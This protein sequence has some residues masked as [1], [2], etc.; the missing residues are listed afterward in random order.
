MIIACII[1]LF[2]IWMIDSRHPY[3]LLPI[4]SLRMKI[5]RSAM[6]LNFLAGMA[7]FGI[8]AFLPLYVQRVESKGAT[9][10]GLV[11]TPM[12]VGWTITN[13]IGGRILSRVSLFFLARFGC[14]FFVF[15]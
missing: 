13:I 10:A 9:T 4:Q 15:V 5:P 11:L 14:V 7:Y 8:L 3:P 1:G 12:I 2:V 6:N